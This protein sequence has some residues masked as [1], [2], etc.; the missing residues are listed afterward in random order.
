M[1]APRNIDWFTVASVITGQAFA[2]PLSSV[3]IHQLDETISGLD[4]D[5][6]SAALWTFEQEQRL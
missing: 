1:N 3:P 4:D 5:E 2:A 6:L